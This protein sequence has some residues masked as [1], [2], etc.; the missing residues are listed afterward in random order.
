MSNKRKRS[1]R[2]SYRSSSTSPTSSLFV[3][4]AIFGIAIACCIIPALT[5]GYPAMADGVNETT[6]STKSNCSVLVMDSARDNAGNL[7]VLTDCG[8]FIVK[9]PE[10]ANLIGEGITYNFSVSTKKYNLTNEPP[11]IISVQK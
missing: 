10:M 7:N 6:E 4:K 9:S 8:A 11:L 1:T 3:A 5:S 2:S